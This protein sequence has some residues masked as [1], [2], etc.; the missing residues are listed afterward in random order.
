MSD[1]RRTSERAPLEVGAAIFVGSKRIRCRLLNVSAS[2][3]GLVT[4][5]PEVPR[6]SIRVDFLLPEEANLISADAILVHH[7]QQGSEVQWG[8]M[9]LNPAPEVTAQLGEFVGRVL[10]VEPPP[11][12]ALSSEP[13]ESGMN[14]AARAERAKR[15]ER[16]RLRLQALMRRAVE[17]LDS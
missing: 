12:P 7:Q 1:E 4:S 6:A 17:N 15:E 8:V 3:I 16:R 10:G 11:E 2:G 9:L 13:L 14:Y 5:Y